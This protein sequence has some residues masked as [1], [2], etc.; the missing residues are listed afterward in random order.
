MEPFYKSIIGRQL[1]AS[2]NMFETVIK[3]CPDSLWTGAL[4]NEPD[5]PAGL[6]DAWYVTYHALFWL[7]LYLSGA[8]EGFAPP[9]PFDLAELDPAGILPERV[10]TQAELLTYLDHCRSKARTV[11]AGLTDEQA[12]RLCSFPW[13]EVPFAELLLDN[14]RHIQ[15]HGA[16]LRMYLGQQAG[17]N[18]R[19]LGK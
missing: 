1:E 18:A 15:E 8:V 9:E 7:D 3:S 4:W 11:I 16:Q 6:S 17:L 14:M 2:I 10:Y 13:G 19:W 5:M 12:R